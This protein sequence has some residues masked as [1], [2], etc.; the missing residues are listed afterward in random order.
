MATQIGRLAQ[1][2]R[3]L[4]G[5]SAH[6]QPS[7]SLTGPSDS[8]VDGARKTLG[9]MIQ[10]IT[11]PRTRWY[12]ADLETAFYTSDT[13]GD[14]TLIGQLS[15]AMMS[16]GLISGLASTRTSGLIALPKRWRGDSKIVDALSSDNGSRSVFDEMCP[17]AEVAALASDGLKVGVGIGE[18]IDVPG[19]SF[20]VLVRLDPEFLIY[21]R[22]ESRFYYRSIAGQLPVIPGDGRWV[23]HSPGGRLNPWQQGLWPALG[24]AFI[25]K[26]HAKMHRSN[27]SAKLANP[28]R[29]AYTPQSANDAQRGAFLEQLMAWGLNTV[30]ALPP[31]WET[32]LLE[33]NG[34]GYAVFADEIETANH[35][36]MIALAGQEVTVT[37]GA[38]FSNANIHQ[39][40]RSDLIEHTGAALAFTVNTQI[41]PQYVA[42]HFGYGAL[43]DCP[44]LSWDTSPPKDLMA[45]T[46]TMMGAANAVKALNEVLNVSK[47]EV[48]LD[49]IVRR[50]GIPTRAFSGE[51]IQ[52][53]A[54]E[55]Q[56]EP[57]Q[58]N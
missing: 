13:A 2:T 47:L 10:P 52:D 5:F 45:E 56:P 38:G 4:L 3:E 25:T 22:Q 40:I 35:E 8:A 44:R 50:F 29:V 7:R 30:F 6:E 43:Y 26:S 42:K 31:G 28:A 16:D 24:S 12:Q 37:G 9:G 41:L 21:R 53:G 23:L 49:E 27:F 11:T 32:K 14:L 15:R 19:R 39:T 58:L 34:R 1:Y 55:L 57:S 46:A 51:K 17:P 20:P 54:D 18:L 33:S 36:I 48:D